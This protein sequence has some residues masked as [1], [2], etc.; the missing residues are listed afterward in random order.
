[1]KTHTSIEFLYAPLDNALHKIRM[2]KADLNDRI[3]E[4]EKR[5][6][7]QNARP[8]RSFLVFFHDLNGTA[9]KQH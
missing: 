5:R 4:E 3:G 6:K 9:K 7:K 2:V 1:M 8:R